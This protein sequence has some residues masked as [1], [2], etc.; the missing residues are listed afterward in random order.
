MNMVNNNFLVIVE[1]CEY[2]IPQEKLNKF[3]GNVFS[4]MYDFNIKKSCDDPH[5][6]KFEEFDKNDFYIIERCIND[7]I[8]FEEYNKYYEII[9]YYGFLIKKFENFKNIFDNDFNS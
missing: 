3:P 7:E 4:L 1:D 9:N 8:T 6:L 5:I 2:Q